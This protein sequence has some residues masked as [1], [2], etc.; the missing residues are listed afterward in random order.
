MESGLEAKTVTNSQPKQP[1]AKEHATDPMIT[2][3]KVR[4]RPHIILEIL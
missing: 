3:K 1:M 4:N 2:T